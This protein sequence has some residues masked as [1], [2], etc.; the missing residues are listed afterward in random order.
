MCRK[1]PKNAS[2]DSE[3]DYTS[4]KSLEELL[5]AMNKLLIKSKASQTSHDLLAIS[6]HINTR[7]REAVVAINLPPIFSFRWNLPPN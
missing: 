4:E 2:K 6:D 3:V 1:S 5:L 7:S